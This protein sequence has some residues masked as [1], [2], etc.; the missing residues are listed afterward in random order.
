MSQAP[1]AP[2]A[3][4]RDLH[5]G[6]F[7][8][9]PGLPRQGLPPAG[10]ERDRIL[11][12]A[13]G[14]PDPY[15]RQLAAASAD[16]VASSV[17]REASAPGCRRGL[18]L[19]AGRSLGPSSIHRPFCGNCSSSVG[20]FAIDEDSL[21]GATAWPSHPQH[22]HEEDHRRPRAGDGR[23]GG[24]GR[25]LRL[26]GVAGA[27][28]ASRSA[29]STQAARVPASSCQPAARSTP[30]TGQRFAVDATNA[31]V[32]VRAKD[33]GLPAPIAAGVDGDRPRGAPRANRRRGPDDGYPRQRRH[34]QSGGGRAADVVHGADG[35]CLYGRSDGRG[36]VIS[37]GNCHR[38][39][40]TAATAV[41]ARLEARSC[42][43]ARRRPTTPTSAR[44]SSGVLPS[45]L[46]SCRGQ[47]TPPTRSPSADPA[48]DGGLHRVP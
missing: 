35:A 17:H 46:V 12:A 26:A 37:M 47:P 36:G 40:L 6:G 28:R 29:S 9:L 41:A 38:A 22:K 5:A 8:P 44:P 13:L 32:F 24:G 18:H 1:A 4:P 23:R 2:E 11:L 20:P 45:A 14:G 39:A 34:A 7:E 43:S 33:V 27:A 30:W 21:S 25:R 10:A 16:L 31:I 42:A 48:S 3:S 15:G 19:R